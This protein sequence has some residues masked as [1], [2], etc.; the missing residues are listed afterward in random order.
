MERIEALHPDP[1]KAGVR[2]H[3]WKYEAVREAILS[4]LPSQEPGLLFK[5]LPARVRGA[6]STDALSDLGSVGWYTTTVKLDLEA[7]GEISRVA[8]SRP[9]RLVRLI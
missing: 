2:I 4:V 3:R 7:R 6:L 5:E 9:Q 8:G 1:E